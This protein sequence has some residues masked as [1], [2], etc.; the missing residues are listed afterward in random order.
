MRKIKWLAVAMAVGV[1][2]GCGGDKPATEAKAD[3]GSGATN[4]QTVLRIAT[5]GTYAPYNYANAD[6]TLAGFDVDIANAICAKLQ[7]TCDIKAQEWDGIIPALKTGKFD[8]IVAAMSVTEE[9][10]Q[11]VDFSTP[12]YSNSLVFIA[13]KDSA[14]D[15]A[16][17]DNIDGKGIAAQR[18]TISSQW[19]E[20]THPK[21][22]AQLYGTLNEAFLD[23][24]AG[25]AEAMVADK[26]PALAWLSTDAGKD[27]AVKG[28][29]IDI[30]DNIAVAVDKGNAELLEK[31]NKALADMKADGT[32][33]EIVRKNNF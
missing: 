19:L 6:G 16:K 11:Q 1:L 26:V 3:S 9:R 28:Q 7:M 15:P 30:N 10:S 25:R 17:Q 4:A 2:A 23:L 29:E 33:D 14:F 32:Y 18:A 12:Y 13:K 22:K 21:A 8:A 31:I 27:F 5:E 20:K 24:G